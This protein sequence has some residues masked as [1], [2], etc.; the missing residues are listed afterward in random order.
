MLNFLLSLS[1]MANDPL[2]EVPDIGDGSGG[3]GSDFSLCG[4]NNIQSLVLRN[5]RY[6]RL[7]QQDLCLNIAGNL[8]QRFVVG[9]SSLGYTSIESCELELAP[10]E[11][12][13]KV[14]I[15]KNFFNPYKLLVDITGS[16]SYQIV[17]DGIVK[18]LRFPSSSQC[19]PNNLYPC[20]NFGKSNN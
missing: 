11:E 16:Y 1:V 4:Y 14:E 12:C 20:G 7:T 10:F 19:V 13:V 18:R 5:G 6:Y 8:A 3:A 15:P 17:N 2:T 9:G